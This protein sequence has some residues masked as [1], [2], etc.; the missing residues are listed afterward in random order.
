MTGLK[1]PESVRQGCIPSPG[2][3]LASGRNSSACRTGFTIVELLV[4]IAIMGVLIVLTLPA[5]Q[6]SR[7][8]ARRT[9]CRSQMRQFGQALH[10]FESQYGTFPAGNEFD[11]QKL[12]SWCTRILPDLDQAALYYRYDWNQAWNDPAGNVNVTVPALGN[13]D[14]EVVAQVGGARTQSGA[15]LKVQAA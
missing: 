13:G 4:V 8:S 15:L 3:R 9:Q 12:H 5:V 7:E 11:N 2:M 14:A 10:N 6:Q 1:Y